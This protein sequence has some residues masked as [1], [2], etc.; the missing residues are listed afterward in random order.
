M[1]LR[2]LVVLV[3]LGLLTVFALLNWGAVTAPTTLSLGVTSVQAPLGLIMLVAAGLLTAVFAA[4]IFL[5]QT[6]ALLESRRFSKELH[7][8]RELA[9][10][11]EAS[12][13]T[14]L[15]TYLDAELRKIEQSSV[16]GRTELEARVDRF[17]LDLTAKLAEISNGITAHVSEVEDKVER[18]FGVRPG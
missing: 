7:A 6:N 18:G 17:E 10:S 2:V 5:Q 1:K 15:R 11:A 16:R 4:F 12:R 3:L 8:Q 14:D 13:F 9:D